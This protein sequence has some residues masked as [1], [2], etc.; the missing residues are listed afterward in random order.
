MPY[1]RHTFLALAV[2]VAV[3]AVSTERHAHAQS[4]VWDW[5][6]EKQVDG[7]GR[8]VVKLA[9]AQKP[10]HILVSFG[11]RKLYLV[12][13]PGEAISYPIAVP[14]E[15]SRWQGLTTVSSMRENPSWTPTPSMRKTNPKLPS[16][17]PGGH[18]MNPLGQRA[19]YLGSSTYRIHGTDAPWTIGS[20]ASAGCVRLYNKDVADLYG[21]VKVGASVVVTWDKFKTSDDTDGTEALAVAAAT[22]AKPAAGTASARKRQI[23]TGSLPGEAAAPAAD[24]PAAAPE[25]RAI[26][27]APA[28]APEPTAPANKPQPKKDDGP[29]WI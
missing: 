11:D 12:T 6:G 5:G 21:R 10:G 4:V 16:W 18:P 1:P 25:K 22:D 15:D 7:S 19:L 3:S 29:L 20:A 14:R 13:K 9:A 27:K 17:V 8:K 26:K 2:V 28:R 24:A 23:T